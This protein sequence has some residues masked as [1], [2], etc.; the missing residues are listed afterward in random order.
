MS[1][2][3]LATATPSLF[4]QTG[5]R[6]FRTPELV[7]IILD[8]FDRWQLV[9][10][11]RLNSVVRWES[12]RLLCRSPEMLSSGKVN[13]RLRG[14]I[15]ALERGPGQARAL[16]LYY[17]RTSAPKESLLKKV[18]KRSPDLLRLNIIGQSLSV[19]TEFAEWVTEPLHRG[20]TG[21][22]L[23]QLD[24]LR[25]AFGSRVHQLS[26]FTLECDYSGPAQPVPMLDLLRVCSG[27]RHLELTELELDHHQTHL[28]PAPTYH[29]AT[30][31]LSYLYSSL[32][33]TVL[34]WLLGQSHASLE[35]FQLDGG[36][37]R[38]VI[39]SL[40]ALQ[41]SAAQLR[42]VK[43]NL[44]VQQW[45]AEKIGAI[46]GVAEQASLTRVEV[47]LAST[48]WHPRREEWATVR[49]T[50]DGA[51]ARL[52]ARDR[53]K[54][55]LKLAVGSLQELDSTDDDSDRVSAESDDD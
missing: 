35:L 8:D 25:S 48:F 49:A 27:L 31:K 39:G 20:M 41:T 28:R 9:M 29:L 55:S 18:V 16:T 13:D 14:L 15:T 3:G 36:S 7:S 19:R 45:S 26:Y 34:A 54:L 37:A 50:I 43:L 4:S 22:R 42:Q 24:P 53:S 10:I 32:T 33:H 21:V 40:A 2:P 52:S 5:D 30:F 11:A 6:V 23:D 1:P 44:N 12:Q 47:R 17:K 46:V 38:S 51:K